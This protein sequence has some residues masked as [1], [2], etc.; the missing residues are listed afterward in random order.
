MRTPGNTRATLTIDLNALKQNYKFLASK[1]SRAHLGAVLKANA[2]GIGIKY[3]SKALSELGCKHFFVATID[4][5]IELSEILK[6]AK[7][8]VFHGV[9][10]NSADEMVEN[11]LIPVLNSFSQ[12]ESWFPHS[13]LPACL[14]IDTGMSRLGLQPDEIKNIQNLSSY[15]LSMVMSHLACADKNNHSKNRAQLELF[16]LVRQ[17]I[18]TNFFSLANSSGIFLGSDY[19]F[20]LCRTGAALYGINP[21][22]S[23]KNPMKQVIKLHAKILQLRNAD[24]E[25]TVGYG[26]THRFRRT[27]KLAT[28]GIGYA[29]GYMRSLGNTGEA[30]IGK[31][32]VPIVGRISMDLTTVD[33]TDVP[34]NLI[35]LN[36]CVELIGLQIPLDKLA[37]QAETIGY[38]LLTNFGDRIKRHYINDDR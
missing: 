11:S 32:K 9:D 7:I 34:E 15:N 29:D 37:K 38:E 28:L 13:R 20:D 5:G 10:E 1:T 8:Y 2:Y 31:Y 6:E 26:A 25:Q 23:D 21:T 16:N 22:P 14:H 33:V 35:S 30:F 12:I 3:I 18:P 27:S 17:M 24:I 4:E 19:H 36:T